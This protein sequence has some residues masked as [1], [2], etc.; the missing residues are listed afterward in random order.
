MEKMKKVEVIIE[1]I[2]TNRLLEIFRQSGVTGYTIIRDIEGYGSHG[3]KT[4]DEANSLLSNNYIFTVCREEKFSKMIE[5]IRSFI[6]RY[7][8]KCIISDSLVLLH[9]KDS[10]QV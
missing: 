9:S 2:Y 1:S 7:G 6:D 5:K 4:A 10:Q 8:G 3:L